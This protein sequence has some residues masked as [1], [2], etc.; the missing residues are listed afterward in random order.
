MHKGLLISFE[1]LDGSGKTTQVEMLSTWLSEHKIDFIRTR[2]PGG[3][4]LGLAIRKL[5]L[6]PPEQLNPLAEAFLFQVDRAQHFANVI[7][8]SLKAGNVVITDRCFD[9]SMVYQ[10]IV[11]GLGASFVEDLSMMAT[12]LHAPNLTILLDMPSEEVHKRRENTEEVTRFDK[13]SVAF[14][15]RVRKAF[16]LQAKNYPI[17]IYR[18]DATQS[19][20]GV[21]KEVISLLLKRFPLEMRGLEEKTIIDFNR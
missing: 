4:E 13:E 9:S 15:E 10:G 7:I 12:R 3:T 2:E 11:K 20:E 21:H 14:H 18:L 6:E 17:R 19:V 16:L 5:I 1:G 8:P